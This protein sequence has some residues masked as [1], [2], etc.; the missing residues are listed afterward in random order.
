MV[1]IDAAYTMVEASKVLGRAARVAERNND[2]KALMDVVAGWLEL[3]D[4]FACIEVDNNRV[5]IGFAGGHEP[6][7]ADTVEVENGCC[8]QCDECNPAEGDGE[9]GLHT[10]HGEF[11]VAQS[12]PKRRG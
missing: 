12:R 5:P 10:K 9:P 4:R 6:M 3:H 2:P 1:D 7:D 11:R 8:G